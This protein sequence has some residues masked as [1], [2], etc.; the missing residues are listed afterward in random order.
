[1]LDISSLMNTD[2]V[3]IYLLGFV[4]QGHDICTEIDL[5]MHSLAFKTPQSS[6]TF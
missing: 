2:C 3:F 6:V 4:S 1:M 5:A